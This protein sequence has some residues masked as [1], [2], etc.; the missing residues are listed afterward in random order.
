MNNTTTKKAKRLSEST[1]E[2]HIWLVVESEAVFMQQFP[3]TGT[4][5]IEDIT[6]VRKD[7]REILENIEEKWGILCQEDNLVHAYDFSTSQ[8]EVKGMVLKIVG[9]SSVKDIV[10]SRNEGGFFINYRDLDEKLS[11]YERN[12]SCKEAIYSLIGFLDK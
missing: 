7:L 8:G 10:L 5:Q 2:Y 6:I 1:I 12:D 9:G 3:R 11:K 4:L